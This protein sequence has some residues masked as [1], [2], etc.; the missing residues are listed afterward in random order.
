M[1][2]D[3]AV[4]RALLPDYPVGATALRPRWD[5]LPQE[6][7]DLVERRCGA[8]V[9][10]AESMPGGFTAGF[11][12]RLLLAD[13]ARVFVKAAA[14][15]GDPF[16]D[17]PV[18]AYPEEARKLAALPPTAPAPRLRWL[19]QL[20]AWVVLCIDDVPGRAPRRPWRTDELDRVLDRAE[21]T[22]VALTPAPAGLVTPTF[23]GEF[24]PELACW[25]T[26]R[27]DPAVGGLADRAVALA[28]VGLVGADGDTL[29][30]CDLRDDNVILGDDG[31]VWFCDWNWPVTGAAWIDTV[32]LLISAR[33]DG[34]DADR[35]LARRALT[36]D[37][38][39]EVLDGMLA[40]LAGYWLVARA[41][42]VPPTSPWVRRHQ[43]WYAE[44]TWDWVRERRRW[45]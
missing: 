6:V 1:P 10:E 23:V 5:A 28:E 45:R 9:T 14:R 38:D 15:T 44:V 18:T 26:L 20:G 43:S 25:A 22:A 41:E 24:R 29:V 36:R 8:P 31:A 2:D 17:H 13:G 21:E 27:D 3:A 33:G 12:S 30:H 34:V 35:V 37:V 32:T 42:P 19:E 4:P 7:R 39:P 16:A 40:L 11:A